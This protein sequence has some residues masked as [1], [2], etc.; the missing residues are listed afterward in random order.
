MTR[1][2]ASCTS[3]AWQPNGRSSSSEI[4]QRGRTRRLDLQREP[5]ELVVR[6]T[7]LEV[8]NLERAA[9]LD[10]LV[11]DCLEL[12]RVDEVPFSGDDGGDECRS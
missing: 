10:D 3:T 4:L 6:A 11:E 2:V 7:E 9:A 5:R 1:T 12:L 8:L